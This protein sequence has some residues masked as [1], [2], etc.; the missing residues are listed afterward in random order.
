MGI[1]KVVLLVSFET[2]FDFSNRTNGDRNDSV[3]HQRFLDFANTAH[4]F[5]LNNHTQTQQPHS[6]YSPKAK[7]PHK[8]KLAARTD[9]F[10][11]LGQLTIQVPSARSG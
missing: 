4:L 11:A 2:L 6:L 7:M 10:S 3:F 9:S 5:Q 8:R 1:A